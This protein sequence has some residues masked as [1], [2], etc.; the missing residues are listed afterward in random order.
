MSGPESAGSVAAGSGVELRA[1]LGR[2][3]RANAPGGRRQVAH[4]VKVSPAEEAALVRLAAQAGVSV[5]RLLVE[6]ALAPTPGVSV[7]ER[8][9][10][11]TELFAV[12][13]VLAGVA[14]NLNQLARVA[15]ATGEFPDAAAA[16]RERIRELI[17]RVSRAMEG[18][19]DPTDLRPLDAPPGRSAR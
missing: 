9:E 17:P 7:S 16:V 10:A 18:L 6:A 2:R 3:R 1:V 14:T 8:R 11:L 5:P 19:S 12:S 4:Q 13:R 15:N